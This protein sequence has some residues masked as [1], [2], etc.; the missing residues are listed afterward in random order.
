MQLGAEEAHTFVNGFC[1]EC[2]AYEPAVQTGEKSYEIGNGGQ[3]YWLADKINAVDMSESTSG[4]ENLHVTL[5]ADIVV[6]ENV[7]TDGHLSTEGSFREWT[8]M[9]DFYDGVFDGNE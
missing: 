8:P 9:Q 7:L 3:L 1:T 6:N 2:D 4:L 5:T